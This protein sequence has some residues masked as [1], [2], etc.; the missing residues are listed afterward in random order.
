VNIA[1]SALNE[2]EEVHRPIQVSAATMAHAELTMDNETF[3]L[4]SQREYAELTAELPHDH[5]G[6]TGCWHDLKGPG[7]CRGRAHRNH[8]PHQKGQ[9]NPRHRHDRQERP[10]TETGA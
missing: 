1:D 5:Q 9:G 6:P 2:L 4:V 3:V 10:R 7:R 8:Q